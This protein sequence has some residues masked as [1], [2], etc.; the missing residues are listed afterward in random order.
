MY[1]LT[2]TVSEEVYTQ[3]EAVARMTTRAV[4]E[5]AAHL[6]SRAVSPL[7][8]VDLPSLAQTVLGDLDA[9]DTPA[10]WAIVR[11]RANAD[12]I[13]LY[14]LLMARRSAGHLTPDGERL[15]EDLSTEA[16]A[17]MLR[18]AYAYGLLQQRGQTASTPA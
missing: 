9:L 12:K 15:L 1:T 2:L 14:D 8:Q 10:L 18:V 7:V 16:D 11:S 13:A 6:V 4:E 17:L 5:V 3:L